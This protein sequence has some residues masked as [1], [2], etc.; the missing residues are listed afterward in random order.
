MSRRWQR[1]LLRTGLALAIAVV[2]M[3]I[4][5][6]R[7]TPHWFA[8]RVVPLVVFLLI[9]Y[10]GKLLYDTLFFDRYQP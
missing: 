9:C 1:L 7:L 2:M 8:F 3:T 10:I 5:T 4:P 6:F